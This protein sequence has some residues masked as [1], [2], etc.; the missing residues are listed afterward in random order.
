MKKRTW[1]REKAG[2]TFRTTLKYNGKTVRATRREMLRKG[3][4]VVKSPCSFCLTG[5]SVSS[6]VAR[7][8]QPSRMLRHLRAKLNSAKIHSRS[9]VD[10]AGPGSE[11][12]LRQVAGGRSVD[13]KLKG[14]EKATA[15]PGAICWTVDFSYQNSL[16]VELQLS[17]PKLWLPTQSDLA[18]WKMGR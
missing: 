13:K 4:Q 7:C 5:L 16:G 14:G 3:W 10:C 15:R 8:G 17:L 12:L 1:G 2:W 18:Q 9:G 6:L 11:F